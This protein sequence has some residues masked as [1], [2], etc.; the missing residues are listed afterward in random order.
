METWAALLRSG[1]VFPP[2]R[3]GRPGQLNQPLDQRP[4]GPVPVVRQRA[5]GGLEAPGLKQVGGGA[6]LSGGQQLKEGVYELTP[7]LGR[8]TGQ[9]LIAWSAIRL[10]GVISSAWRKDP[11]S[12]SQ[13]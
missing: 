11:P 10:P 8:Q 5:Q 7:L 12:T 2:Y 9:P 3:S 1:H 6:G 4:A 13:E